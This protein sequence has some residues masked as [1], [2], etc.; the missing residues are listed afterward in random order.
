MINEKT[1]GLFSRSA[2]HNYCKHYN[3]RNNDIYIEAGTYIGRFI[4]KYIR[5]QNTYISHNAWDIQEPILVHLHK[6]I[7]IEP[8][9]WSADIINQII[10]NN[11]VENGI[12]IKKAITSTQMKN[13]KNKQN[14]KQKFVNWKD[15][16]SAS[17]MAFHDNDFSNLCEEVE[18]ETIDDI[19]KEHNLPRIDLLCGDV[20]GEEV[21]MIKGAEESLKKG[22]IKNIAICT[23]HKEP[24]YH[25]Q[26]V[27]ILKGYGFNKVKYEDGITF[28]RLD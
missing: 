13:E 23:Y 2:D 1:V 12:L 16:Y 17:R 8:C 28:A 11:I 19:V 9:T 10:D 21:N 25:N 7:L 5:N 24:D 27:D 15:N 4:T 14:R 18:L 6:T 22:L 3:L 26:I 20:E